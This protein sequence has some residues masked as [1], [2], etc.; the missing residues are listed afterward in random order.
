MSDSERA[1]QIRK[2]YQRALTRLR[3]QNDEQF[4]T[5]LAAEYEEMGMAVHKRRSRMAIRRAEETTKESTR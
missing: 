4:Q 1:A 3:Q 5:L 2:A